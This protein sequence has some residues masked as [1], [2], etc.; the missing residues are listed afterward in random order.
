MIPTKEFIVKCLKKY[1]LYVVTK[2]TL[3]GGDSKL[4]VL[5]SNTSLKQF[6]VNN[7][8]FFNLKKINERIMEQ[9]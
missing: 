4:M 6:G 2:I 8:F 1:V 3:Q 9:K 7:E 5:F